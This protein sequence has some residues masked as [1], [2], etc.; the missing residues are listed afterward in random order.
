MSTPS[1]RGICNIGTWVSQHSIRHRCY[2]LQGPLFR[3][4]PNL[5]HWSSSALWRWQNR[6]LWSLRLSVR[7][8][9]TLVIGS[10][11]SIPQQRAQYLLLATTA[12]LVAEQ[13]SLQA[14]CSSWVDC[15]G[16]ANY[17]LFFFAKIPGLA[18]ACATSLV[19][20][21]GL[22]AL[23]AD[24]EDWKPR[25]LPADQEVFAQDC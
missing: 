11:F 12:T 14:T 8:E 2:R 24:S 19:H 3:P 10:V 22:Q 4:W 15:W 9:R 21:L 7:L 18:F 23:L 20:L 6:P 1:Y 17:L 25:A 5:S 13:W 16:I